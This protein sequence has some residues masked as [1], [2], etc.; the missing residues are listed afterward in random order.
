MTEE[1]F[2]ARDFAL[3]WQAHG[4]R[5]GIP[6]DAIK[7]GVVP[8]PMSRAP[9]SPMRRGASGAGDRG[10][11]SSDTLAARLASRGRRTRRMS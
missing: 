3:Q 8:W 1:Q 6:P 2:A 11:G 9:S 10:D 4:L 7:A 5:Y